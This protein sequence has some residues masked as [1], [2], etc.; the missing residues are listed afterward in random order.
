MLLTQDS[1][2]RPRVNPT[3]P[4]AH[5]V[6]LEVKWSYGSLQSFQLTSPISEDEYDDKIRPQLVDL[7]EKY[8][9]DDDDGCYSFGING[10]FIFMSKFG[11]EYTF[12]V[13]A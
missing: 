12:Q 4:H 3:T 13:N 9:T 2:R 10:Y 1:D 8:A 11:N 6:D 5:T 7:M